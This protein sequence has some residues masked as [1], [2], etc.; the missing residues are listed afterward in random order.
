MSDPLMPLS[1][2]QIKSIFAGKATFNACTMTE[3]SLH[4]INSRTL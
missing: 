2:N 1:Q 4:Q 3:K